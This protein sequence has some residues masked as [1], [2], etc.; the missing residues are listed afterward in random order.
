MT[1]A[2]WLATVYLLA[3]GTVCCLNLLISRPHADLYAFRP[4]AILRAV[5]YWPAILVA[6]GALALNWLAGERR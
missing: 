6:L 5:L 2:L 4:S 3:G 1:T